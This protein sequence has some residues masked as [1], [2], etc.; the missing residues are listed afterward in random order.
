MASADASSAG[1]RASRSCAVTSGKSQY[2][3]PMPDGNHRR[4]STHSATPSHRCTKMAMRLT[5]ERVISFA[6][7]TGDEE[8]HD[9]VNDESGCGVGGSVHRRACG[10]G[11]AL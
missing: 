9:E 11:G 7:S 5:I 8:R 2:I 10:D 6:L 3:I 1:D 4:N